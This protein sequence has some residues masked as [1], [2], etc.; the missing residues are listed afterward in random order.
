MS[1]PKVTV[2]VGIWT[3]F[4]T[5]DLQI[6]PSLTGMAHEFDHHGCRVKIQLP[7]KPRQSDWNNES[8]RVRCFHYRQRNGRKYPV[9][10][11]VNSV[12]MT[13]DT[14]KIRN[15][16]QNSIGTLDD[17]LFDSRQIKSLDSFAGRYEAIVDSAFERWLNV[18]RWKTGIYTICPYQ[19]NIQKSYWGINLIDLSTNKRFYRP[20]HR[21][22]VTMLATVSRKDWHLVQRS[23]EVNLD[24]PIWQLYLAEAFQRK[25]LED[26]RGFI[27]SLAIA[28]ESIM[29][30]LIKRHIVA[31]APPK[32][33][34]TVGKIGIGRIL[35]GWVK[36][37]FR[38][39]RWK[40]LTEEIKLV[41]NVFT[42]RNSIMH[43]GSQ[44]VISKDKQNEFAR[45]VSV[46]IETAE[47]EMRRS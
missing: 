5:Y 42:E 22:T 46:F 36:I 19:E 9:S 2:S 18:L 27:L 16:P 32:F 47:K 45:A 20:P 40:S 25:E 14:G 28:I 35:D 17:R 30:A 7:G 33:K 4:Q 23:L 41:K 29:K 38:N 37:N 15:I 11:R 24:V 1:N 31:S 13:I 8:S 43:R 44:P 34:E 10:Y 3:R 39:N 21:V 6:A 26:V 12:D